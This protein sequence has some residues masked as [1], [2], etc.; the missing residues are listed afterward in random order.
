MAFVYILRCSDDSFY[1]GSTL[2]LER[3]LWQH[4][5]GEGSAYT[6]CRLPVSVVYVEQW[7]RVEDAFRCEKQVQGWGRAKRL[8]LI[9]GHGDALPALSRKVWRH[10][11]TARS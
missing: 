11:N 1:V 6:Q 3:R 5:M 2:D 8:A 9:T 10:G 7:D 4:Q